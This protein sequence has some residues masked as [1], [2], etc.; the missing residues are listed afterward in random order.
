MLAMDGALAETIAWICSYC[1]ASSSMTLLNKAAIKAL[2]FPY[3][4]CVFQNGATLVCLGLVVLVAPKNHKVFGLRVPFSRKMI[5][6]WAPAAV[7][8]CA[9]LVTSMQA[10]KSMSVTTVLVVR[11]LTPLV[12]LVFEIQI[13]GLSPAV[14]ARATHA[15]V[16]RC[17]P[18]R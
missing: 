12:T 9:M 3:W 8:F 18:S 6:H 10:M 4:L 16:S 14:P 17:L 5:K 7:L 13:L 11:A 2:A 15:P 1:L